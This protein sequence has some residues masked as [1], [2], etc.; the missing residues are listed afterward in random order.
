MFGERKKYLVRHFGW[1]ITKILGVIICCFIATVLLTP[2][3]I[4]LAW[5]GPCYPYSTCGGWDTHPGDCATRLPY[6]GGMCGVKCPSG[7]NDQV[8][9]GVSGNCTPDGM[10]TC[11]ASTAYK[12]FLGAYEPP[13]CVCDEFGSSSNCLRQACH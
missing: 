8:C 9:I 2:R 6:C 7:G 10:V 13:H 5:V 1:A 4:L 11:S 12:C 3:N